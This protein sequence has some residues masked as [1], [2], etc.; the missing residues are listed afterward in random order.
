VKPVVPD[1]ARRRRARAAF[2]AAGIALVALPG[3]G[4][5]AGDLFAVRRGGS[6]P[7]ARLTLVVADDGT[8]RCGGGAPRKLGDARL[9]TARELARQLTD[10]ARGDRRLPPGPRS[11]LS[12]RVRLPSGTL[13]YDDSSPGQTAA[14][15]RL[16]AFVRDV[17]TRV[18]RLAR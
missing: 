8:V 12:Y 16:Q 9:L 1:R 2:A 14:M 5:P 10:P 6:I 4:G 17:A 3:C 7:G 18:C 15:A 13:V 11:V